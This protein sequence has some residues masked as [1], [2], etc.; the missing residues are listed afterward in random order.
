[1][2]FMNKAVFALILSMGLTALINASNSSSEQKTNV[3]K[4]LVSAILKGNAKEVE[5]LL[6]NNKNIDFFTS[7]REYDNIFWT[8]LINYLESEDTDTEEIT[9]LIL[10]N[11]PNINEIADE[12]NRPDLTWVVLILVMGIKNRLSRIYEIKETCMNRGQQDS[13]MEKL[14]SKLFKFIDKLI[15]LGLNLNITGKE[16]D[17][18][19]TILREIDIHSKG[20]N[21]LNKTSQLINDWFNNYSAYEKDKK[22]GFPQLKK[23][24]SDAGLNEETT[25][26]YSDVTGLIGQYTDFADWVK[27]VKPENDLIYNRS[28]DLIYNNSNET[29]TITMSQPSSS[30]SSK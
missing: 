28:W 11:I 25:G 15:T 18:N 24:L 17:S 7:T 27:W 16:S 4:E 5:N 3:E 26:M 29:S 21:R 6:K 1:M 14:D 10:N 9:N 22:A 2:K 8:T 12:K 20:D 23:V 13:E 30:S 19:N